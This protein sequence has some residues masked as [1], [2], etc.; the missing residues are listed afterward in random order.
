[1][2]TDSP[3]DSPLIIDD[4]TVAYQR[5]PVL[6]DVDLHIP[7]GALV[8]IIGP[9]GAGKSTLIKACLD[10]IPKAS[11]RVQVFGAPY[12][13]KR[14]KVGYVPQ[15]ESVDWD[16]PINALEV[17]TMGTYRSLGWCRPVG[18]KQRATALAAME[19][20]GIGHLAD[21]QISELSG[22]QQQRVFSGP[23]VSPECGSLF[24]GRALRSR[25]RQNRTRHY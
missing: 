23:R 21:R 2:V 6:W 24:H 3:P 18:K 15:R 1:M 11:G 22:G 17:V 5:K 9:N 7:P 16:F 4:L 20:V 19:R 12:K 13:K 14:A 8:G 10:L 25:G